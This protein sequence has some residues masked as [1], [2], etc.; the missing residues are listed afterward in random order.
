MWQPWMCTSQISLQ[1]R[2]LAS[3]VVDFLTPAATTLDPSSIYTQDIFSL[4]YSQPMNAHGG[5]NR[6]L[7]LS[8][9]GLLKCAF[10]A[11]RLP[12]TLVENF[13]ELHFSLRLLLFNFILPFLS[14]LIVVRPAFALKLSLLTPVPSVLCPSLNFPQ[15][16]LLN[17]QF[18]L[19]VCFQKDLNQHTWSSIFVW[20]FSKIL[21]HCLIL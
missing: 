13:S 9:E 10:F 11:L 8:H 1:E 2:F 15:I 14:P 19:G 18:L 12:I 4:G 21:Y 5:G 7:F 20:K 16:N 17:N 3:N 6:A